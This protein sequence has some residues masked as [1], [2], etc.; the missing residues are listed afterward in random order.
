M[1]LRRTLLSAAITTAL[2]LGLSGCGSKD[3]ATQQPSV[4]DTPSP[5]APTV[6]KSTP[7]PV[8]P[9][10]AAKATVLADY[11][12]FTVFRTRGFLSNDPVYP[13][14]QA[15]TGNALKAMKSVM[16]GM[17]MLGRKYTGNLTFL[18]GSVVVLNLK[19]K[20]A[21]ATVQACAMDALVLRDKKGKAL[22]GAPAKVSTNDKMVLVGKLWKVTETTTYDQNSAG[23]TR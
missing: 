23:C 22:T 18:K 1:Q 6:S 10:V 3:D 4:S 7:T 14:E 12:S 5:T 19:A 11:K 2:V 16:T 8:D 20:P 15:M 9:V 13:F 17:N 21:T